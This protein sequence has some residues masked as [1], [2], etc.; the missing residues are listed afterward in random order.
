MESQR[1]ARLGTNATVFG[2]RFDLPPIVIYDATN[3]QYN[4]RNKTRTKGDYPD[5][6]QNTDPDDG[7]APFGLLIFYKDQPVPEIYSAKDTLDDPNDI[8]NI[9]LALGGGNLLADQSFRITSPL[10]LLTEQ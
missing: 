6:I 7:D 9:Q 4:N 2:G 5:S 1:S 8:S 10:I 3:L